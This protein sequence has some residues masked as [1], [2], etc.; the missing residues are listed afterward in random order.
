VQELRSKVECCNLS[1]RDHLNDVINAFCVDF[2]KNAL[3]LFQR[4]LTDRHMHLGVENNAVPFYLNNLVF[5][6]IIRINFFRATIQKH[7]SDLCPFGFGETI[8][9]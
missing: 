5:I 7:L 6:E 9:S 3:K 8:R 2:G 1:Y 4:L